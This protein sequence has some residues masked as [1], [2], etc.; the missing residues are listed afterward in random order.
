METQE[1]RKVQKFGRFSNISGSSLFK[2][3]YVASD[4]NQRALCVQIGFYADIS[5]E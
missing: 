2:E 3:E 1:R 4:L 5:Q